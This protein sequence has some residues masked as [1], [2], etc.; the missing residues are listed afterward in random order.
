VNSSGEF[1]A[2]PGTSMIT[3]SE[4]LEIGLAGSVGLPRAGLRAIPPDIPEAEQD[5]LDQ[6]AGAAAQVSEYIR[7]QGPISQAGSRDRGPGMDQTPDRLARE[8][9]NKLSNSRHLHHQT[10]GD[11]AP[12]HPAAAAADAQRADPAQSRT[13]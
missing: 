9:S 6:T 2:G 3:R 13:R 10:L 12:S 8:P 1:T 4:A 7:Q 5:P 11:L